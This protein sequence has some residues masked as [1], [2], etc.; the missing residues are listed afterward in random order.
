MEY[1]KRGSFAQLNICG[2][3]M[4]MDFPS[5]TFTVQGQGAYMLYLEQKSHGE[6]FRVLLKTTK[7]AKV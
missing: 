2:I 4:Y 3:H 1:R 6:N 5:N 7:T